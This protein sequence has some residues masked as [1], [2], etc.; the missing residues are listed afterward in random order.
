M[1]PRDWKLKRTAVFR[2]V[3]ALVLYV[4]AF[5]SKEMAITLPAIIMLEM[6]FAPSLAAARQGEDIP[7]PWSRTWPLVKR[8]YIAFLAI[9]ALTV[10]GFIYRVF[11]H[12][13]SSHPLRGGDLYHH[14]LSIPSA[15]AKYLE[16]TTF[17]LRLYGDYSDYPA[18][19]GIADFRVWIG[20]IVLAAVWGFGIRQARRQPYLSFGLLWFGITMIPVR[21]SDPLSIE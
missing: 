12:S 21:T 16:L 19:S 15:Y 20:L 9:G 2:V 11:I 6:L 3:G 5:E 4:L 13:V 18:A 10:A 8:Y 17:P 7:S 1:W 14:V